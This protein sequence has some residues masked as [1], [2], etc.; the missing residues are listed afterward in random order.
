MMKILSRKEEFSKPQDEYIEKI[1]VSVSSQKFSVPGRTH[2]HVYTLKH[3]F[4]PV[5][6]Y[7]H[8]C[9]D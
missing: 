2:T 8:C 4:K 6:S 3:V 1:I 7:V 5:R 9:E